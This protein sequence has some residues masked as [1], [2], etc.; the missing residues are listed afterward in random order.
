N[1]LKQ[2][3]DFVLFDSPPIL[4]VSDALVLGKQ[5]DGLILVVRAGQTPINALKQARNKIEDHKINCLG[6]IING[7]S[8]LEQEGYYAR[9]YY[10]Y[11]KPL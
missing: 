11:S 2:Q 4:A 5:V 10:H 7:V 1:F 8:L 3:F 9:Q 6:V